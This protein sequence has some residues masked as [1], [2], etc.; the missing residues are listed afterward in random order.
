[1]IKQTVLHR[2][3]LKVQSVDFRQTSI[4]FVDEEGNGIEV[5]GTTRQQLIREAAWLLN[6]FSWKE[7]TEKE[8]DA[9]RS[10]QTA[11]TNAMAI[12]DK[13]TQT[14]TEQEVAA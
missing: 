5:E 11:V 12:A 4:N 3:S 8:I 9:L 1:M 6:S 13:Q 14:E 2:L 10:L 7:P